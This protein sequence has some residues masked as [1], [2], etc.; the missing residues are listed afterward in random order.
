MVREDLEG[1]PCFSLPPSYNI[2]PYRQGDEQDWYTIQSAADRYNTITPDLFFQEFGSNQELLAQRQLYLC[3]SHQTAVGT[4]TAWFGN[5]NRGKS[6]GLVHWVAILP[7]HQGQGLAKPL[8]AA[9]CFRLRELGHSQAYLTTSTARI[10]A[11]NLY[12]LF[13]FSAEIN[14]AGEQLIWHK[15]LEQN[16]KSAE[17]STSEAS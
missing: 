1:I 17:H 9:T 3:D 4:A 15:F 12:L 14:N 16:R 7:E 10:A 13:G 11:I 2:R 5:Q 6:Y 8:M